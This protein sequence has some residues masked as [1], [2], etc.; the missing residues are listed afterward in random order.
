MVSLLVFALEAPL[1]GPASFE[2][3]AL[4]AWITLVVCGRP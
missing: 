3:P 1:T 2:L 4:L